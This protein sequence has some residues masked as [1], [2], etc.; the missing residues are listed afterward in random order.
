MALSKSQKQA[1]VAEVSELLT[2]SKMT[3]VAKYEGTGVKAM[4]SLR[5]DAKQNG[6]T[7]K[8]VKNRLVIQA[9]KASDKLKDLDTDPFKGML[10]YAFNSEDEV[11]PA[12]SLNN[13]AKQIPSL[14]FVG[15]ITDEGEFLEAD[16][17]KAL[18]ILPSKNQMLASIVSLLNSPLQG[19]MSGVGGK[20]PALVQALEAKAAN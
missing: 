1:V 8:V 17:V 6:T 5:K 2:S 11:A 14:E 16:K 15:A 3:V 7:V 13:F 9:I 10:L 4:Q 19:I 20:L 18:A 12:Q